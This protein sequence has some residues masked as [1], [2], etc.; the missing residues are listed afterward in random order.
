M[1]IKNVFLCFLGVTII[2]TCIIGCNSTDLNKDDNETKSVILDNGSILENISGKYK[3]YT[4]KDDDYS[5][6]SSDEVIASYDYSSNNYIGIHKDKY[7]ANYN[8]KQITLDI[9]KYD[10]NFNISPNGKY[11]FFFRSN[12]GLELQVISL[13]DGSSIKLNRKVAISGKYVDWISDDKLIYYGVKEDTKTNGLFTY[14]LSTNKE[15]LFMP[16]E[17]G[18]VE[19][20]KVLDNNVAY[21][22]GAFDNS[23]KFVVSSLKGDSKEVISDDI[24]KVYDIEEIDNVFYLL[25]NFTDTEE[26]LYKLDNNIH[27]RLTYGFPT[28][29]DCKKG[30]VKTEDNK[31]LFIGSQEGGKSNSIYSC[32][33][34]GAVSNIKEYEGEISFVRSYTIQN[35]SY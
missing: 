27:T 9:K 21:V 29:V 28:F 1:K 15:E 12:D 16:I 5:K 10:S 26:S 4:Y 24:K 17:D 7:I 30:L 6:I 33:A 35:S 3:N 13:K 20:I 25:G 14:D 19:F 32:D 23:K 11:L 22:Q 2:F 8:K 18:Y 34:E 31:I